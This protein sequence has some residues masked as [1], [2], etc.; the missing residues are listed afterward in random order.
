MPVQNCPDNPPLPAVIPD[1]S[2][3]FINYPGNYYTTNG[4]IKQ[5]K[6]HIY[7][8]YILPLLNITIYI[9]LHIRNHIN[10]YLHCIFVFVLELDTEK[11]I[12]VVFSKHIFLYKFNRF[13]HIFPDLIFTHSVYY[14]TF[15]ITFVIKNNINSSTTIALIFFF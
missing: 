8:S 15:Y 10:S 11:H 3:P 12:T 6:A 4:K 2:P 13:L 9:I 7:F 14:I 1:T 5:Q